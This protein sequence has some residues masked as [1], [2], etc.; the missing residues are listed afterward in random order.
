MWHILLLH[1]LLII[2]VT[3]SGNPRLLITSKAM[4]WTTPSKAFVASMSCRT[5]G[6]FVILM[7]S[8]DIVFQMMALDPVVRFQKLFD[9]PSNSYVEGFVFCCLYDVE[10]SHYFRFMVTWLLVNDTFMSCQVT[11][12]GKSTNY[13]KGHHT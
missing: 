3:D 10:D 6:I 1:S 8:M 7:I 12:W 4:P 9:L 2:I 11:H 5:A 13:G